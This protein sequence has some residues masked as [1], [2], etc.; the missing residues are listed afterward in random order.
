MQKLRARVALCP[1]LV[2][3]GRR[4]TALRQLAEFD[5]VRRADPHRA[6]FLST[7]LIPQLG[8][9]EAL[10]AAFPQPLKNRPVPRRPLALLYGGDPNDA[11]HGAAKI[12]SMPTAAASTIEQLLNRPIVAA[13][14]IAPPSSSSSSSLPSSAAAVPLPLLQRIA[15]VPS[16]I[17]L[18]ML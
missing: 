8:C 5:V 1:A 12:G 3:G 6:A 7:F 9:D 2:G 18:T 11:G 15:A 4:R 13:R 17:A 10:E 14:P 16:T